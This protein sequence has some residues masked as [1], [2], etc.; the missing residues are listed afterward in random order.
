MPWSGEANVHVSIV[1]WIKGAQAGKKRLYIQEGI[2]P[3]AGWHHEDRE[4][5]SSALSYG[6]DVTK[7][8]SL[9][10]NSKSDACAQGQTHGHAA[11]LLKAEE[12]SA[13]L[14]S[15][16][17]Y[18][19]V[20]FPFLIANTL[21]ASKDGLP[22]RYVI[23]FGERDLLSAQ[24]YKKAY[25]RIEGKV[26]P[27]RKAKADAE[28]KRNSEALRVNPSAKVNRHHENF[29]KQWWRMSYRRADLMASI[30][31]IDRYIA[32]GQVTKRPIFEFISS[33]IHPNAA[34]VVFPRDDDYTFGI[35]QS[36]IHWSWFTERCSTLTERYRY[37]KF[38][39]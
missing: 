2:D 16:P 31:K 21:F 14:A 28:K 18:H 10:A 22:D 9:R 35:L 39:I 29:L 36:S 20:I 4:A 19:D 3:T 1:N 7:A 24:K 27:E 5:I 37:I 8:K 34:L 6:F 11:F 30:K 38:H 26:L 12:A 25:Q 32:C 23:D 33:D 17:K 13:L 15:H